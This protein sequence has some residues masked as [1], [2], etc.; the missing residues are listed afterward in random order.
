[1]IEIVD[2]VPGAPSPGRRGIGQLVRAA[3]LLPGRTILRRYR[4]DVRER[5]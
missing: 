3:P 2:K 5:S 4:G 1:M